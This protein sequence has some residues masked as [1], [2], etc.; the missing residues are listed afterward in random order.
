MDPDAALAELR[1][2][3]GRQYGGD[4]LDEDETFRLAELFHDLD[5]WLIKGSFLPTDWSALR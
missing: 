1:T 2:L 5:E 3:A 4:T